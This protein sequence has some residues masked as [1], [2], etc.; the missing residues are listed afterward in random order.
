MMADGSADFAQGDGPDAGP[1]GAR[2]G[3]ALAAL[4]DAGRATAWCKTL[5]VEAPGKF[6][7][8]D[9]ETLLEQA[10]RELNAARAGTEPPLDGPALERPGLTAGP[11][12]KILT[13]F[14]GFGS[15]VVRFT[16][17]SRGDGSDPTPSPTRRRLGASRGAG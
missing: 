8:S 14:A 11:V 9:A 4:L 2:H 16:E 5:N 15:V 13:S 3:P 6:E 1:D 12:W 7:V 17:S 10:R